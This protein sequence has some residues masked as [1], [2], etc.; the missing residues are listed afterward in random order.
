MKTI[1]LS[2]LIIAVLTFSTGSTGAEKKVKSGAMW[3]NDPFEFARLFFGDDPSTRPRE[4]TKDTKRRSDIEEKVKGVIVEWPMTYGI[5]PSRLVLLE[6]KQAILRD[7]TIKQILALD[8]LR[9]Y[10]NDGIFVNVNNIECWLKISGW[11]R[12][13]FRGIAPNASV[14]VKMRIDAVES[15]ILYGGV[16]E[17]TLRPTNLEIETSSKKCDWPRYEKSITEQV[18]KTTAAVPIINYLPFPVKVGLR[19]GIKGGD[20]IVPKTNSAHANVPIG[21]YDIYFHYASD[22][23]SLYKGDSF[24]VKGIGIK[25]TLGKGAGNYSIQKVW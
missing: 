1:S 5:D 11:D 22:P 14:S 17:V 10:G 3:Q 8:Q 12:K 25:I 13:M 7:G 4:G 2:V 19:S 24:E 21:K 16:L 15:K 18:N 9:M 6:N 23:G 20:F